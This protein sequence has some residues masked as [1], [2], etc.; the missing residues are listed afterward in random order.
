M[1]TERERR[2]LAGAKILA[3][4]PFNEIPSEELEIMLNH[5]NIE[6]GFIC[7]VRWADRNPESPWVSVNDRMPEDSILTLSNPQLGRK[8]MK[9]IVLMMDGRIMETCRR[10]YHDRQWYWNI[11]SRMREQITHWMPIPPVPEEIRKLNNQ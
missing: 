7:G 11:P 8:T 5:G 10:I 1:D 9:V 4:T 2:M 6:G 3:G